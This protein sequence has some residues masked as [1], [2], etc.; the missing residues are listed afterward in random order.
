MLKCEAEGSR[1]MHY[2]YPEEGHEIQTR[3]FQDT[4]T[5]ENGNRVKLLDWLMDKKLNE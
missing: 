2:I 1:A 3:V 4:F 5:D